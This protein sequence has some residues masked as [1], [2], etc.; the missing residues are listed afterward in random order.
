MPSQVILVAIT[1]YILI[2]IWL[3]WYVSRRN[4]TAEDFLL[5]GRS[6]SVFLTLGTT[7]ATMVGTGSSMGA[8]G[9]AYSNG[10]AGTL[11]GIGGAAGILVL[12]VFFAGARRECHSTMSEEL[13]SYVEHNKFVKLLVA[14]LMVAASIG[15]LGA[16]IIGGGLYLAWI[17]GIDPLFAK[18][19]LA[20]GFSVY[21][22]TGGYSAV[23]WTDTLQAIILFVGF[24]L[25]AILSVDK[26]GGVSALIAAQPSGN[27]GW[28]SID[29]I[30]LL[31][32]I[33]LAFVVF[34]GVLATPSFR[35]RIYS[36]KS[37]AAVKKS[38]FVAGSLY[39]GFSIIPAI[40]G[41]SA[42]ALNPALDE[43]NFAF[44]FL[45]LEVLPAAIGVVVLIA[46]LSATM[47]SASS[48][49]IAAASIL[50]KDIAVSRSV[51]S[52]SIQAS[53]AGLVAIIGV[54]LICALL[55]NDIIGYI[56]KMISI[57]MAGLCVCGFLGR[58]WRPFS[59]HGAIASL[60]A[61]AL[62]SVAILMVPQWG[63]F[64]GNPIIP[65]VAASFCAGI[66]AS[67]LAVKPGLGLVR[68]TR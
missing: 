18:L 61:G 13:A 30:G 63:A 47:S 1:A 34:V 7:V 44:P 15:W 39:L 51:S 12:G 66:M 32:A 50:S 25:M 43:A 31:P 40:I 23:V 26:V 55:S 53:R 11:Y 29:K 4:K 57:I 64:W 42:Y 45:A 6:L 24:V 38:F 35:Q 67:L 68:K 16:H 59:W 19:I 27:I 2:L 56:S 37:E 62:T 33:S 48:D 3:G 9:F 22:V 41:M 36:A 17:G 5:S 46:G 21:V 14:Y 20:V 54:A 28:F 52:Q 65:S 60:I 49:A 58:F 8:V 10:W